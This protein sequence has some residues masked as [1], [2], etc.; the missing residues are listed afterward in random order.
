MPMDARARVLPILILIALTA[1]ACGGTPTPSP[2]PVPTSL[3]TTTPESTPE[4]PPELTP[5]EIGALALSSVLIEA[6]IEE[7][8]E[9]I[10]GWSGSGTIL[11]ANGMI[12]TNAHV[13]TGAET[14]VISLVSRTDQPP[15]PTYYAEPVEVSNVLDL[16]LI[17]IT[18]DLDGNSIEVDQLKLPFVT[19]GD[20][21][22]MELGQGINVL[23]Y[24]GVGG[25]TLTF[26]KGIVSGFESEDLGS[27]TL[28]RVWIKS[29]AE[30]APGN[31][32]GTAVDD[33]GTLIGIPTLVQ[34]DAT[35]GR[36]SRLRPSNLM[37]YLLHPAPSKI[38]DAS[39]YEPNDTFADAYGPLEPGTVYSSFI[40][41]MDMDFY[42]FEV[43]TLDPVEIF[44]TDIP[45]DADYDLYLL[46]QEEYLLEY[47]EGET[48]SEYIYHEPS[49]TGTFYIVVQSYFGYTIEQ[50]YQLQAIFNGEAAPPI[51]PEASW[52]TVQGSLIDA[53]T[54]LGMEGVIVDVLLPGVTGE[55]YIEE[56][57]NQ[58]LVLTSATTDAD[59]VF[60]LYEIPRGQSYTMV[61]LLETDTLWANDFLAIESSDPSII[62]LGEITIA[63]E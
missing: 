60:V 28:E 26:T 59:G 63:P 62:D 23:G 48:T 10:T 14:L 1:S 36:I 32:G 37:E 29:D 33:R 31:S 53:N 52:V 34:T 4:P 40:H 8:G 51:L 11:T 56:E 20:S 49:E 50:P 3:P 13:V 19:R 38:A 44:L 25:E 27:G 7:E 15:I 41:Q 6:M 42:F 17:Q 39:S 18:S 58:G 43:D 54:G 55:E 30:I 46:S 47:S 16:A 57:L 61:I 21:D 9:L 45:E 35:A 5:D 2:S 22:E 24:P 12:L